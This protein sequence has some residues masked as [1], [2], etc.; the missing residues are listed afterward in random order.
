PERRS[1]LFGR[2]L[3]ARLAAWRSCGVAGLGVYE[4]KH[5]PLNQAEVTTALLAS[6]ARTR[7]ARG[8]LRTDAFEYWSVERFGSLKP[9]VALTEMA[10]YEADGLV[11]V[12]TVQIY[13]THYFDGLVTAIDLVPVPLGDCGATLVRVSVFARLDL[14]TGVLAPIKSRTAKSHMVDALADSLDRI[15]ASFASPSA[16]R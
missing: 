5:R 1:A 3:A 4:D 2:L 8:F 12:E 11:R 9:V 13:A 10:T 7:P 16:I 6:L 14:F 15:R